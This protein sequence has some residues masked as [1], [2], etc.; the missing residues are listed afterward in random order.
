MII[1]YFIKTTAKQIPK[2][3]K[4]IILG[5][6]RGNGVGNLIGLGEGWVMG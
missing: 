4:F 5:E 2:G 6:G 3:K 1:Q